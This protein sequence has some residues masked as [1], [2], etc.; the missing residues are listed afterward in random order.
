M[1]GTLNAIEPVIAGGGLSRS[2]M[3]FYFFLFAISG[4]CALVYEVVWLR[5]AMAS[6]G[7]NTA[8]VSILVSMFMAGLGLGCWGVGALLQ[9]QIS[10]AAALRIYSLAELLVFVSSL[11]VPHQ[12]RL[13]R[14]LLQQVSTFAA[15]QS[16]RYYLFAG[17]WLAL[18]LVPWCTCMGSTFP[19]LMAAI[20]KTHPVACHRSFS[21]LY[22]ANVFGALLGALGSAFVIIELLGFT[23]T[24]YVAGSLNLLLAALAFVVSRSV[25]GAAQTDAVSL[26]QR[27]PSEPTTIYGLPKGIVLVILFTT[28]LV[29]M[30]MEVVWIRQF[31][32]YL[33]NVVYTFA[34]I[35]AVYL[36]ATFVGSLDYRSWIYSHPIAE[37]A[38]A[39]SLLAVFAAIPVLTADPRVPLRLG[40]MELAGLR[41]AGIVMFC[42]LL[43]FLTPLV[44][45]SRSS[46]DPGPAA[47][48][49]TANIVGSILG[50]LVTGFWLLPSFGERWSVLALSIP[51]FAIAAVTTFARQRSETS[52]KRSGLNP[53]IKL[54]LSALAAI[55]IFAGCHDYAD[56]FAVHRVR[57]DYTATVVAAGT[58]FRRELLVNGFGMTTLTPDTKYMTHLPLA[59]LSRPP[60]KGLVI[61]F[62][63]G[64]SFRS[65]LSW[66]I[67]TTAV[68]LVPSVPAMFS[69]FHADADRVRASPM[70]RVVID[71]GRRFMD[72]SSESYD[73]VV[74]DPPPPPA[75]PGSS[76]LYSREFYEIV[77]KHMQP[78]G[79]L[80]MWYPAAMGDATTLNSITKALTQSFPF[81]RAFMSYEGLGIHFLASLQALPQLPSS[82]LAARL[83][84]SAAADFLEWG[85]AHEIQQQFQIALSHEL[86]LR[87]L[88]KVAP[89]SPVLR[90]DE[91]INEYFLL[92]D[93]FHLYR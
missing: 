12:L 26:P 47:N 75:A 14:L 57:R 8:I 4:F 3:R 65:M 45:D 23:K 69:Y 71:D 38:S 67:P 15:W 1:S 52:L 89:R 30:G 2:K 93:W 66:G 25:S 32:P 20:K 72:G 88:L 90:D 86:P 61:C 77:K 79:I 55:A 13:G 9:P 54:L 31:T 36:L 16:S 24:L 68:D 92:R 34:G 17:V 91:P 49:Y 84:A 43:G 28:G 46:G 58:G 5:L 74:V 37:S 40:A 7:V 51:L 42:A 48:A 62:G 80:Q 21:Y 63:M 70:A 27:D 64:T 6:F 11:L 19:L 87:D 85:P 22:A 82:T 35:V 81:V 83:P 50:P 53:K 18:T 59:F 41:L 10:G 60:R 44:I 56:R 78:D 33:G 29:S 39:W 76:L 73:V